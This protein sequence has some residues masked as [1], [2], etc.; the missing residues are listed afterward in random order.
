MLDVV[1]GGS[2]GQ[3]RLSSVGAPAGSLVL[4]LVLELGLG[5]LVVVLRD[6]WRLRR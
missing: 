3:F 5:A 4:A 2:V 1:A 6:A